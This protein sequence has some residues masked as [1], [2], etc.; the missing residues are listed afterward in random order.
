[1]DNY[2]CYGGIF[3]RLG[4]M[5]E[6]VKFADLPKEYSSP[7][8]AKIVI[9]PVPYD[10]TSTWQKGA[11]KGP[12]ALIDASAHMELYDIE[13]DSQVY[14]KGIFTAK[15]VDVDMPPE[16]MVESV[17]KAVRSY[18]EKNKFVVVVGGEHSVST[19]TVKAHLEK[20]KD[21]TVLQLDAHS[22]LRYEYEGSK[23]NH[24]CVMSRISELCPIV[25]VGIRSTDYSEQEALDKSR[26]FFAENI[27][28]S[29][30]WV[31]KVLS[32]LT[33]KVYITID[34]DV[35][36][37]SIMPSTG[38][39][40][41]GGLLWYNVLMLLKAVFDDKEVV[42]FDVVELCPNPKNKAPDFLAAKLIYK[43]LS[44][45]YY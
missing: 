35:F 45:K 8:Q 39:P 9:V 24:A 12:E 40:E 19:G 41:P 21:F 31:K 38:T 22:D 33:K 18:L 42:G 11:D 20:Y 5:R 13:T 1:M 10:G 23:Y 4:F 15:P 26:V 16:E 2:R 37:P 3:V 14:L 43:L 29:N 36:D 25:Q 44:Y 32:L 6:K 28:G 7:E 30:D 34:L 27:Y 17:E